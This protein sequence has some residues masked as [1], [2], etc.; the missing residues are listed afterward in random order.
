MKLLPKTYFHIGF[1]LLSNF[2]PAQ[3]IKGHL[4]GSIRDAETG[5]ALQ[6][7]SVFFEGTT[8]GVLSNEKG[9]YSMKNIPAGNYTVKMTYVGY[10]DTTFT[11]EI[12]DNA[13]IEKNISLGIR[14]TLGEAVIVTAQVQGQPRAI[15]TQ[16]TALTIKNVVSDQKIREL[17]DANAAEAL[18]RL[19]GVSVVREYGEAVAVKIRGVDANTVFVNGM[20]M[21]GGLGAVSSSMIGSIELS[22]AFMP[23]QDADILGGSVDFRMREAPSGF[24]KE[25]WFRTGYNGFIKS[26]KMQDFSALISNRFF[27]DKLGFMLGFSYDR[28]DRGNDTYWADYESVGSSMNSEQ[29]LPVKLNQVVLIPSREIHNRYGISLFSDFRLKTGRVYYQGFF[30]DLKLDHDHSTNTLTSYAYNYYES[31]AYKGFERNYLNGIGGE[32]S[33]HNVKT[34]WGLSYSVNQRGKD[35]GLWY[36]ARN[37][38]GMSNVNTIDTTTTIQEF[39]ALAQHEIEMT[40]ADFIDKINDQNLTNELAFRLSIEVPFKLGKKAEGFVKFGGKIRNIHREYDNN[41]SEGGIQMGSY[42]QLGK[43]AMERLPD[44][45]WVINYDGKIG[46]Q[47]FSSEEPEQDF[48]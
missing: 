20:R 4:E 28:K 13:I 19:P 36:V 3:V 25:I 24:K 14:S 2:L 30:N 33:W 39:L 44:Y 6:Y 46:H 35:D 16:I 29:I 32:H 43:Y 22:K 5:E 45:N 31:Y 18:S 41:Q 1:L 38:G 47:S 7:A 21:D 17:P 11:V 26:F 40:W 48:P 37:M 9:F 12:T 10:S 27:K 42:E 23:D 34:D 8:S 15:N